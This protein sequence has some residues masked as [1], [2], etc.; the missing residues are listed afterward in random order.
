MSA[1]SELKAILK[2]LRA[3]DI[4]CAWTRGQTF[5]SLAPQTIEESYELLDAIQSNDVQQIKN[6]LGDMLYHVMFYI[7]IAEESGLFDL[8]DVAQVS[9]DKH[10]ARMP[11]K[12]QRATMTAAEVNEHWQI[13]KR[14]QHKARP[15]DSV[16]DGIA[17]TL[18]AMIQAYKLQTRAAEVG[19]DWPDV[20]PVFAKIVE[21]L[22]ELQS[23]VDANNDQEAQK[24]E[25]GD[26]LFSCIN[27]L[28]HLNIDPETALHAANLKFMRRFQYIEAQL[29]QQQQPINRVNLATLEQLWQQAKHKD[30]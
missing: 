30:D 18:P 5:A 26:L 2:E 20:K 14:Q 4:G 21:E 19:F 9:L 27:L 10:Q 1:F 23:E 16:L 8:D 22:T 12:E 24:I 17:R 28:R 29:A 7:Q 25:A 3:E 6:E 13:Y 11:S 15:Q